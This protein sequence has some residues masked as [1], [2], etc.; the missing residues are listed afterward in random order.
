VLFV[1]GLPLVL[2]ELKNA[3]DE[4]ASI[5]GAFKQLGTYKQEIPA[6]FRYN[7]VLVISDGT[8]AKAGTLTAKE[9][10]FSPWKTIN[11]KKQPTTTPQIEVLIK[12]MLKPEVLLDLVRNFVVYEAEKDTKDSSLKINKKIGMWNHSM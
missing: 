6:I 5:Q 8:Y 12:G 9:E 1:N 4:N 10:R 11:G 2:F 7:E 3:V